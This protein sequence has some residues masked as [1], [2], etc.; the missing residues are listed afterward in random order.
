MA[1]EPIFPPELEREIFEAAALMHPNS[2][3]SLSHRVHIWIEPFLYIV[4]RIDIVPMA[5]AVRRETKPASFFQES[6]RHLCSLL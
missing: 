5:D 1:T 4:I 2:I 6:V 3:P